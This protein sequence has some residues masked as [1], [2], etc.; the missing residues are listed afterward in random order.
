MVD[1]ASPIGRDTKE[2]RR[3]GAQ[4]RGLDVV[5]VRGETFET[6]PQSGE[7]PDLVAES[8]RMFVGLLLELLDDRFPNVVVREAPRRPVAGNWMDAEFQRHGWALFDDPRL[9]PIDVT[10]DRRAEPRVEGE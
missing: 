5:A 1:E 2:F 7:R 6:V 10:V 8:Q 3:R 9:R 4:L